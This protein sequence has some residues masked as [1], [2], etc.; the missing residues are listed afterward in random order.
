MKLLESSNELGHSGGI[1]FHLRFSVSQIVEGVSHFSVL[2]VGLG[3]EFPVALAH[4]PVL[5]PIKVKYLVVLG[6]VS[7]LDYRQYVVSVE[8]VCRLG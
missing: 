1:V 6:S 4:S 5:A 3:D 8:W 2:P 7:A